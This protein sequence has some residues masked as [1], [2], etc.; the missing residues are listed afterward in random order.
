MFSIK[1]TTECKK[2]KNPLEFPS[3]TRLGMRRVSNTF[4]WLDSSPIRKLLSC[5]VQ[6]L[7]NMGDLILLWMIRM[8]IYVRDGS[9]H[10]D[11]DI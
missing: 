4:H 2:K 9:N 7:E 1:Y 3:Q 6:K 8:L 5:G 10:I 11:F